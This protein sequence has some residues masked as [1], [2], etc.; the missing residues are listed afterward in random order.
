LP[1]SIEE[2]VEMFI[3][4]MYW[5]MQK[6]N[7]AM[8]I[9]EIAIEMNA[10]S[11]TVRQTLNKLS[12]QVFKVVGEAWPRVWKTIENSRTLDEE[13][14]VA[15]VESRE[16]SENDLIDILIRYFRN[17]GQTAKAKQISRDLNIYQ[18]LIENAL[19]AGINQK[20][21][22]RFGGYNYQLVDFKIPLIK[23]VVSEQNSKRTRVNEKGKSSL[24]NGWLKFGD[25]T[26]TSQLDLS[27]DETALIAETVGQ[28]NAGV[29]ERNIRTIIGHF[30]GGG[31]FD[32]EIEGLEEQICPVCGDILSLVLPKK[33]IF[34]SK[35]CLRTAQDS[36]LKYC[37]VEQRVQIEDT[38]LQ[39]LLVDRKSDSGDVEFS[40]SDLFQ[41][42]LDWFAR[43]EIDEHLDG[44][45]ATLT[46]SYRVGK[47]SYK[48]EPRE[49][50]YTF[51]GNLFSENTAVFSNEGDFGQT[52]IGD[53]VT[54]AAESILMTQSDLSE[55]REAIHVVKLKRYLTSVK[56][57]DKFTLCHFGSDPKL[58]EAIGDQVF[59]NSD[60]L[61]SWIIKKDRTLIENYSE[62]ID[63]IGFASTVL[64]VWPNMSIFCNP[65]IDTPEGI[66]IQDSPHRLYFER[67]LEFNINNNSSIKNKLLNSMRELAAFSFQIDAAKH[68]A[69]LRR[70]VEVFGVS[71][72]RARQLSLPS[73]FLVEAIRADQKQRV[74]IDHS[75]QKS[76]LSEYIVAH[77]GSTFTEIE[78]I[79]KESL[80]LRDWFFGKFKHL[81]LKDI[82]ASDNSVL[83]SHREGVLASLR[84]ASMLAHPLT[85][86]RYQELVRSGLVDG[87]S[88]QR[89]LQLFGSWK[90]A[91]DLAGVECG[92]T[93]RETYNRDFSE[94]E[95]LRFVASYLQNKDLKSTQDG[96]VIWREN[97]ETPDRVPSIGT[98]RNRISRDWGVVT[99]RALYILRS[100]WFDKE[101]QESSD[102]N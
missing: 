58:V 54:Q 22:R 12:D 38:E 34:C 32:S 76:K 73:R 46:D 47:L 96:Y 27:E 15:Y 59:L 35:V 39:K 50:G 6:S 57:I 84:A 86:K 40:V 77:P 68:V 100:Q 75:R 16:L 99:N 90:S 95:C 36:Y 51:L 78:V 18:G 56:F 30:V 37:L 43:S 94:D 17:F 29:I 21:F 101:K 55:A 28:K 13:L 98:V 33:S 23:N 67:L 44:V 11:E 71:Y 61:K 72:E 83:D 48:I 20:T 70:Y 79:L 25:L 85:G 49:R 9:Q 19:A 62:F 93:L 63:E 42:I 91:C 74:K 69:G 7:R 4:G 52:C 82:D 26:K 87:L 92:E 8:S 81:V 1:N 3:D 10:N 5:F 31:A 60:R 65:W 89:V 45:I 53:F 64:K 41:M 24:A 102:A 97:H 2:Q 80:E 14:V 88:A 66:T